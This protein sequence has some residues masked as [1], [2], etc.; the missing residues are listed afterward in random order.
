MNHSR[1]ITTIE[2]KKG[3]RPKKQHFV[4]DSS[5]HSALLPLLSQ[6]PSN[7]RE[8]FPQQQWLANL[9]QN[10]SPQQQQQWLA[11]L[12]QNLSPQQQQQQQ[13]LANLIQNQFQLQQQQQWL[14]NLFPNQSL[15]QQQQQQQQQQWLAN[16]FQNQSPNQQ[17]QQL[18]TDLL[19]KQFQQQ[20]QQQQ[21]QWLTTLLQ[22]QSQD[23]QQQQWLANL[24]QSQS[25]QQQQQWLAN[26]F[27]SQSPQQQQ[28]WLANLF[29]NQ[30]P[31]HQQQWLANLFLNQSPQQQQHKVQAVP[32][33]LTSSLLGLKST[34]PMQ[35]SW[36][37]E[38]TFTWKRGRPLF[39]SRAI[40]HWN[41][42][43][44]RS[45]SIFHPSLQTSFERSLA[46]ALNIPAEPVDYVEVYIAIP[47]KDL[48]FLV[49]DKENIQY[50][51]VKYMSESD[52]RMLKLLNAVFLFVECSE[53]WT[54][55]QLFEP[56]KCL[57]LHSHENVD[58]LVKSLC[59]DFN[60]DGVYMVTSNVDCLK[61]IDQ[62]RECIFKDVVLCPTNSQLIE[63]PRV[64]I[65]KSP[66]SIASIVDSLKFS[67]HDEY[68]YPDF[69]INTPGN[70]NEGGSF[71]L[72]SAH[73]IKLPLF[74]KMKTNY[75][76]FEK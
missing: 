6:I 37:P 29:P 63:F 59:Y 13:W 71:L 8:G 65:F 9:F 69:F 62:Q 7:D 36:K 15:Q 27:Q 14:A 54:S 55:H 58:R 44:F 43:N 56:N 1:T 74:Q 33:G 48:T 52:G 57:T 25:P 24:F 47:Q 45:K 39:L 23:Q 67:S 18:L 66:Q 64:Y 35:N 50:L 76:F 73:N 10:L 19:I 72:Q 3:D 41:R 46:T 42:A 60:V 75:D 5:K 26:L 40:N 61:R 20:Q 68:V 4:L 38:M 53:L 51:V 28:Q 22:S 49:I 2:R 21:Q 17:Q 30:S 12:F 70:L 11:N 16:S 34:Y 31:Q 32:L